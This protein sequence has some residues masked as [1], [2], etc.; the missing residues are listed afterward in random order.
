MKLRQTI[1]RMIAAFSAAAAL[2]TAVG[3]NT[4][5]SN[6]NSDSSK[7]E[8]VSTE[9][10]VTA[11]NVGKADALV[12]QTPNSVTVLDTGNKGDGKTI[13]KFLQ[14]QGI[15]KIDRMII[16]HYDKDH[17]GG[18]ARLV[19]RM[20]IG[21]I[22]VPDYTSQVSDYQS[23]M[24]KINE[25]GKELTVMKA[26]SKTNWKSDDAAFQLYAANKSN[27]GKDEEN[28][29]S[30]CLYV[31][32]GGNSYL[33][34]GDAESA[35][36]KEIIALNLGRVTFLKFPYHGNYLPTTEDFLNQTAP[37]YA[38]ICC[39]KEEDADPSTVETLTKRNVAAYYTKNG[40]ISFIS[41]GS[42]IT[43]VEGG[44]TE[45][46]GDTKKEG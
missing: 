8:P 14:A 15:T 25:T 26:G 29:F 18:A 20:E 27:Y 6:E 3:C 9:F 11:F 31:K 39:S 46:P 42:D 45:A 4:S 10:T 7:S 2:L 22:I 12:L 33:F 13:E 30:L 36:Q 17:V 19:N 37:K 24:D 1:T 38:L 16:T 34:T 43:V 28:D 5:S 23:F 41:D 40:T 32:H 21:E 44:V 35:R